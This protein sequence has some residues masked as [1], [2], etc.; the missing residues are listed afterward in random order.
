MFDTIFAE[1]FPKGDTQMKRIIALILTLTMCIGMIVS[2]SAAT[3]FEKRI[4]LV[5]LIKMMFAR[6][7]NAPEIGKLDG[8]KLVVYVAKNGKN[9]AI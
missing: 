3:P 2:A 4:G 8:E 5:R 9:D 6:D 7:D 1:Q